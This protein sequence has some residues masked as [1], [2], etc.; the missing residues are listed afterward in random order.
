MSYERVNIYERRSIRRWSQAGISK[1]EIG[2][3]LGRPRCTVYRELKRNRGGCGYRPEQADRKARERARRRGRRRFTEEV[4]NYAE[5]RIRGG[6][7]PEMI[8]GRAKLEGRPSVCKETIYKHI[9]AD[10]KAGGELWKN[11]PRAHRKRRRR[12]PRGD[13][14]RR[15]KIPNQTMI[16]ER[17]PEVEARETEGHWEGD[18][19][20]GDRGTGNLVTLVE[21][22]TRFTLVGY[23]STKEAQ[24]VCDEICEMFGILPSHAAISLTL[25]NGKEFSSHEQIAESNDIAIF[26][27]KPYHSWERGTNE[28]I[29]GLIRRL[30]PKKSSFAEIGAKELGRIDRHLN[31]RPMKCLGWWTPR[32]AMNAW[33]LEFAL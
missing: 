8:S 20:N 10:A 16:D 9:Y 23:V 15:G 21:R 13:G 18:L 6:W 22:K 2:E 26:F 32:E 24:K 14:P 30:Y 1:S 11:L 4:K 5:E 31:D 27:A 33:L 12:C 25:D 28:N 17:P 29:N 7:T 19:I 3:R